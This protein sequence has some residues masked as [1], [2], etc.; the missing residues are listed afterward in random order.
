MAPQT[1]SATGSLSIPTHS[2]V[3]LAKPNQDGDKQ[4]TRRRKSR[5][6]LDAAVGPYDEPPIFVVDLDLPPSERYVSVANAYK[7]ELENLTVLFDDLVYDYIHPK[8]P[9]KPVAA[10]AKTFLRK[11]YSE[12]E[13]E[14]L[15]GISRAI[16]RFTRVGAEI[17]LNAFATRLKLW[18]SNMLITKPKQAFQCIF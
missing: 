8:C 12:E 5:K 10:I 16:G 1:R 17:A 11:L 4:A 3:D 7:A 6:S 13:T 15:R 14:E 18:L 2:F 9:A